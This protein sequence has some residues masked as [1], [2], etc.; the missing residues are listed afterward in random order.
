MKTRDGFTLLI[1]LLGLAA[2]LLTALTL[3]SLLVVGGRES[4]QATTL[5]RLRSAALAGAQ[6]ALGE[7]GAAAGRDA[8]FTHMDAAGVVTFGRGTE[9]FRLRASLPT[10]VSAVQVTV[11]IEDRSQRWDEQAAAASVG[12]ASPWMQSR[13]GRQALSVGP[14]GAPPAVATALALE[15]GDQDCYYASVGRP[16]APGAGW[17]SWGLLTDAA[18]GGWRRNLSDPATLAGVVGWGLAPRLLAPEPVFAA[19]PAKGL[20][21]ATLDSAPY[22]LSHAPVLVDF[23]LSLGCFNARSD[24]RHRVRFHGSGRWW[25]P[26]AAPLLAD[27]N[28]N[29]YLIEVDGA[30]EVEVRNV[31]SGAN[32]TASLDDCLQAD[33]GLFTQGLR[34]QGLW[35]WGPVADAQ[36]HGMS[37]RGLLPG[38]VYGFVSPDPGQQPQGLSRVLTKTT[39]RL[40]DAPRPANWRR[41]SPEVFTPTDRIEIAVRFRG[42]M[43]LKLRPANG[44]APV[45]QAIGEYPSPPQVVIANVAFPDFLIETTGADYSRE[46]SA[47]YTIAERRACLRLKLRERPMAAWL[48]GVRGGVLF[49]PSWDL[50]VPADAAEWEVLNPLTA[51]FEKQEGPTSPRE[52]ILWD[53]YG[54]AHA[55]NEA[56][57]FARLVVRDVP[58]SPL[59]SVAGLQALV[60]ESDRDWGFWLDTAFV[61][62]PGAATR[63]QGA[64]DNPRLVAWDERVP[65][66]RA[67]LLAPEAASSLVV[68]GAFNVNSRDVDAWERLLTSATSTWS[69][70]VG[71][72]W[73]ARPLTGAWWATLP[74]GA[75][76][77]PFGSSAPV[78]LPDEELA[79]L[80]PEALETVAAQQGIR[81]LPPAVSRRWAEAIVASQPSHGWPYPSLEAWVRSG[82]LEKSLHDSGVNQVLGVE[83]ADGPA[84]LRPGHFLRAF[85]PLLTVRGDTFMIRS[86]AVSATGDAAVEVEWTVQRVPETQ[87]LSA[88]GRRFRVIR[89]RIRNG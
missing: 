15:I 40:D 18:R 76:L 80:S 64:S 75:Q 25:N 19:N 29:L 67:E 62:A 3:A 82:L 17:G 86:R 22:A 38:E 56:G 48:A 34:E 10:E 52:S 55:G 4:A 47:G 60:P 33:F 53:K 89:A 85:G 32:F 57:A 5:A 63:P 77:A 83:L 69:A 44:P 78:N 6:T 79:T 16:P 2:A 35:L 9:R 24:G 70:D 7:L 13:L 20:P 54:N 66:P 1:S 49:K 51:V 43:T 88:L 31:T 46:D 72:P 65:L 68:A 30:P 74:S 28:H 50:A 61:A 87:A 12:R 84:A 39:W 27:A 81:Q 23:A 73:E 14:M 45:D 42:P 8:V 36:T 26:S 21:P 37:R 71:G 58:A 59:S 41:P 11:Q